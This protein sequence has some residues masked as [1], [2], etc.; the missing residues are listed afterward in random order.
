MTSSAPVAAPAASTADDDDEDVMAYF[1]RIA[2][3]G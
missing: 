3:A 2:A 1:A